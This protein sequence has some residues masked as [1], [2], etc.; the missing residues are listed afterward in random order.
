RRPPPPL[1]PPPPPARRP[2]PPPA[3]PPPPE[4]AMRLAPLLAL[5]AAGLV[6]A[7]G[8]D[9]PAL[10][11]DGEVR[12]IWDRAPHNA[13]TDLVRFRGGWYCVFREGAGHAGGAG[14]IRVLASADGQRWEP[15]ALIESAGVDLRD[16]HRSVP[17]KGELMLNGGAAEPAT[18]DPVKD[19]YSFV[20]FSADGKAW[21]KPRRVL[22]SWQWLWRVTWRD[23]TAYGV[24]YSWDPK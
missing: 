24:T 8:P 18:R 6:P 19:H 10:K 2:P 22:G 1:S 13:F 21:T 20:C 15:A 5:L 23:G 12:K 17:P 14:K 4:G 11:P 9:A 16:P 3:T 7:A